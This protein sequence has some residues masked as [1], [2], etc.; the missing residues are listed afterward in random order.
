MRLY[1]NL[2]FKCR[3]REKS[4]WEGVREGYDCHLLEESL[5]LI[6]GRTRR[7]EGAIITFPDGHIWG[8]FELLHVPGEEQGGGGGGGGEKK[9]KM[10]NKHEFTFG[11]FCALPF[12]P[13]MA[14]QRSHI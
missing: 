9:E 12:F 6:P 3:R 2:P 8:G 4:C 14:F 13:R 1:V 5:L 10:G 7:G 11:M